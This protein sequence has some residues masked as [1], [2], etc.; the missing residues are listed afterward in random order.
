MPFPFLPGGALLAMV[1]LTT[2]FAIFGLALRAMDRA[3]LAGRRS[4]L[5]GIIS[6]FRTWAA[7]PALPKRDADPSTATA[8]AVSLEVIELTD[9]PLADDNL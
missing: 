6:G 8:S 3:I 4:V 9:G 7:T 2:A 1:V 5:P